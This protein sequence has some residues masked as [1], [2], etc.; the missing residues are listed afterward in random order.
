M[1]K[2]PESQFT[3]LPDFNFE[4][5]YT[6]VSAEGVSVDMAW[7]EAGE[8][9]T[10][11][12]LHGEPSWSFLYRKMIPVLAAGGY[13]AVAPDLVGFGRSDKLP[14]TEDYSYTRHEL[15]LRQC[16][17]AIGGT[18][19]MHLFCQDWGGLLGLRI[20]GQEPELFQTITAGNTFL[21]NGLMPFPKAFYKWREYSQTVDVFPVGQ[22]IQRAT[23]T[24]LSEEIVAAYDAPFPDESYKAAARIFPSL[25]PAEE[26]NPE[27][28]KNRKAWEG[29]MAYERPFL[30]TFSDSDPITKGAD[31]ILHAMIPGTKGQ[32]HTIIEGGGHFLQEDCGEE[33]ARY[34]LDWYKTL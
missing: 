28:V 29:L 31:Q 13:R 26:D 2:T 33:I 20:A 27:A 21:P 18:D 8:G 15:W 1:I 17:D 22:I 14:N 30:T 4:P 32:P 12:L 16:I 11:L 19:D 25:V 9:P 24:E 5:H 6:T 7:V 23:V 3:D 10:V 34:M